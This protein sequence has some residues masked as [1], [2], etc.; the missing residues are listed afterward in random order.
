MKTIDAAY[1][2][3]KR[4]GGEMS[5]AAILREIIASGL[6]EN[7]DGFAAYDLAAQ[8]FVDTKTRGCHSLFSN[9]SK[10]MFS[11][12]AVGREK[13]L[14]EVH[15]ARETEGPQISAVKEDSFPVSEDYECAVY[16]ASEK[17]FLFLQE[18]DE[19]AEAFLNARHELPGGGNR[20]R[21]SFRLSPH[22]SCLVLSDLIRCFKSLGYSV[23]DLNNAEGFGLLSAFVHV[24][25]TGMTPDGVR[26]MSLRRHCEAIFA[27]TMR[28]LVGD[29]GE[30]ASAED[31]AL[32]RAFE[33]HSDLDISRKYLAL[34]YR[35]ASI[36]AKAD[37]SISQAASDCL[38]RIMQLSEG[39]ERG[40]DDDR[41]L[42]DAGLAEM[43]NEEAGADDPIAEL[44]ELVG[45]QSVKDEVRKLVSFIKVQQARWRAGMK[46]TP[47]SYH[48]VFTG[49]PGTGKTIVARIVA[50]I[51]KRLGVL[52]KG[53]LVEVDRADLVGQY[54]G[55]TAIKT[56]KK[57]EE[58]LDGVLFIDEAY[59][60]GDGE[61]RDF[62]KEAVATLLKRMEDYRDRLVVIIAG[63]TN[64]IKRFIDLN[65]GLQSRFNRYI[66]FP[67]YDVESLLEI[68]L[69]NAR[70]NQYRCDESAL[71]ALR[72][73]IEEAIDQK[74]KNFGNARFVRNVFEKAIEAQ[75]TRLDLGAPLTPKVLEVITADDI[76]AT[77]KG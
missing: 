41:L 12:S 77:K 11:L 55:E 13:A 60:L 18:L 32:Y 26:D 46:T 2:V 52:K 14:L 10:G 15:A 4:H 34:L 70:R 9:T 33:G 40:T 38:S 28:D 65:P 51:Y 21:A 57:I 50:K 8:L 3:L 64:E 48:C 29:V 62:G 5:P 69:L 20:S 56:N 24:V 39:R 42:E 76:E 37:G 61:G 49:S 43:E 1:L 73:N 22:L 74:G 58:A 67:D 54:I 45:L 63:Y 44:T 75:A 17:L 72:E 68:F 25:D 47:V 6:C 36:V 71:Q 30:L 53:H 16:E 19:K 66:E 7:V 31:F 59:S 27:E 35:W 23:E